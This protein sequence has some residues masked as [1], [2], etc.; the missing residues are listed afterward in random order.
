[1]MLAEILWIELVL[2]GVESTCHVQ[3]SKQG[4]PVHFRC[5]E[6]KVQIVNRCT[7]SMLCFPFCLLS[8][9]V[10]TSVKLC[11]GGERGNIRF[12]NRAGTLP[13][14]CGTST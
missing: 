3:H 1:M 4:D 8:V 5:K 7:C 2:R 14:K 11:G 12:L 9:T 13:Y 6:G 10:S